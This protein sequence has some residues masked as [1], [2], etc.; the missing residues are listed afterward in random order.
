[1]SFSV[2]SS[3]TNRAQWLAE[4]Q[5][6]NGE[7]LDLSRAQALGVSADVAAALRRADINGDGRLSWSDV[8]T[9]LR[10][11]DQAG[12]LAA[13]QPAGTTTYAGRAFRFPAGTLAEPPT[14]KEDGLHLRF[15]DGT[16][17][18]LKKDGDHWNVVL[19]G[20]IYTATLPAGGAVELRAIAADR[21]TDHA[22]RG[23]ALEIRV[24]GGAW[25]LVANADARAERLEANGEMIINNQGSV[26]APGAERV[27]SVPMRAG[28][29]RYVQLTLHYPDG[30]RIQLEIHQNRYLLQVGDER[31]I[32][33]RAHDDL[34]HNLRL[35]RAGAITVETINLAQPAEAGTRAPGPL[36]RRYEPGST[37]PVTLNLTTPAER[38]ARIDEALASLRAGDATAASRLLVA[39]DA[40]ADY[41]VPPTLNAAT[42]ARFDAA[43]SLG[44]S[45]AAA[46]AELA[47]TNPAAALTAQRALLDALARTPRLYQE[48]SARLFVDAYVTALGPNA[49]LLEDLATRARGDVALRERLYVSPATDRSLAT[50][51]ST[52]V[53][54]GDL[55]GARRVQSFLAQALS[56]ARTPL[57]PG[58][59]NGDA[60]DVALPGGGTLALSG[61]DDP[62]EARGYAGLASPPAKIA[63][64]RVRQIDFALAF[65]R[66]IEALP[67]EAR[68]T[69]SAADLAAV[70]PTPE[71]MQR[72]FT[73]RYDGRMPA[74]MAELQSELR[75]YLQVAYLH[76]HLDVPD[77]FPGWGSTLPQSA[78][79]RLIADCAVMARATAHLLSG[80][81]GLKMAAVANDGHLRLVVTSADGRRGFVQSNDA[82]AELPARPAALE[83]RV[84]AAIARNADLRVLMGLPAPVKIG[85]VIDAATVDASF[86]Q[87]RDAAHAA[88]RDLSGTP[89]R[90]RAAGVAVRPVMGRFSAFRA[91]A[92]AFYQRWQAASPTERDGMVAERSRLLAR[93]RSLERE[94]NT[95][96]TD[97]STMAAFVR[98]MR[99]DGG[100]FNLGYGLDFLEGRPFNFVSLG[101]A[102][103]FQ[104]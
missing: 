88:L 69:F 74:A 92:E 9:T 14:V 55:D 8:W 82:L 59:P 89:A 50:F 35:D 34:T 4:M 96:P 99:R 21:P 66:N 23:H 83:G 5:Q 16:Q 57:V 1:M 29:E 60:Y 49:P 15:T 101:G 61:V 52:R 12:A 33:P 45:A 87:S 11:P 38:T 25:A 73:A 76:P 81:S 93:Y 77:T 7:V 68:A 95:L 39:Y 94:A 22:V 37:D 18:R 42:Q 6:Q 54:A 30:R 2:P 36:I 102:G 90:L 13:P 20:R 98:E 17:A 3:S 48:D 46:I 104:L 84:N 28:G 53:S 91:D 40:R 32:I 44:Q 43:R 103:P 85:T 64:M 47:R 67:A 86:G 51:A 79:G 41:D 10:A 71:V 31:R 58:T 97:P 27:E 75:S 72:Y 26:F 70:P 24:S 63:A 19:D 78:D 80:V 56:D 65:R 100:M 62:A